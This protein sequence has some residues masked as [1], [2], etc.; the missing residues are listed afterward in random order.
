MQQVRQEHQ[1]PG[2][3]LVG[4]L[5]SGVP[6]LFGFWSLHSALQWIPCW[7]C[8]LGLCRFLVQKFEVQHQNR[9]V[10]DGN[11]CL[12]VW[13]PHRIEWTV[14]QTSIPKILQ[15]LPCSHWTWDVHTH[16]HYTHA[17]TH[18]DSLTDVDMLLSAHTRFKRA[19]VLHGKH[20]EVF[21]MWAELSAFFLQPGGWTALNTHI[22]T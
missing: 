6:P 2:I 15:S 17:N 10:S 4:N 7:R 1:R 20:A 11:S 22:H 9:S 16:K 13:L 8:H 3:R 14:T 21:V 5:P 18:A 19:V 12:C